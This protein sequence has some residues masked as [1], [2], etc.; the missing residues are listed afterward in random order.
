[1]YKQLDQ[2]GADE[3]KSMLASLALYSLSLADVL[4]GFLWLQETFKGYA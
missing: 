3:I 1:M 2:E 4:I